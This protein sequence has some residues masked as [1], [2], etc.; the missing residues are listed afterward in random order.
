MLYRPYFS[1]FLAVLIMV[2]ARLQGAVVINE[3]MFHPPGAPENSA[4]EWIEIANSNTSPVDLSGWR[5]SK[6]VDFGFPNGTTIAAGGFLVVAANLNTFQTAHPGVTNVV[7]GWTGRLSNSGE[8][9]QLDR[10]DWQKANGVTYAD[11]GDWAVRARGEESFGH[12]GWVWVS[13]ADGGG[14]SLELRNAAL[15]GENSGQNWGPSGPVGGTPGAANSLASADVAPLITDVK[16]RPEIPHSDQAIVVS[17]DLANDDAGNVTATLH[18]RVDGAAAWQTLPM[19][20][21]DGDGDREAAIP[22]QANLAVIEFYVAASDGVNTRTWPAPA[23]TSNPGVAPETYAQVTNALLQVDNAFDPATNFTTPGQQPIYRLI[24]TNAERAELAQIGSTPAEKDSEATMNGTFISHDGQGVKTVYNAGFRNRG[25]ASALGPPNNYHVRFRNDDRWNGRGSF[26]LNCLFPHSQT[27]GNTLFERAGIAPQQAAIVQVRV[28]GANLAESGPRMYGR[29]ARVEGRGGEW[30]ERHFPDDA[31]GNFYRLDDHLYPQNDPRSGEFKF[32]GNDPAAYADTFF[33]ETN[34]DA[35]D[36]SDLIEFARVVSAPAT[37]GTA[38]QPAIS[39]AAYP[40][41]VAAKLDLEAFYRYMATDALIGNQE[42]GLQSGRADD[43]SIYRGVLDPRF[44]FVPH[45]LDDVFNIGA[46]VGNP[47]TRS[48][49]SYNA[50]TDGLGVEG[51]ARLFNHPQLLPRYYAAVLAAMDDWFNLATIGPIIDGIMAGWVPATDASAPPPNT[52]IAEIKAFVAQRRANVLAQIQQNYALNVTT[53]AANTAEGYSQTTDG[54]ATLG[55]TFNLAQ[56]YSITVNG[57]LAQSFYRTAGGD[58]AGTWKLVVPAGGGSI[59]RRGLNTVVVNFWGGP[60]GTGKVLQSL[61]AQIFY[62]A[63]GTNIS[64]T[65]N[66]N[67]SMRLL[68]PSSFIAG[69]P[70]LVRV[71]LL[72]TAGNLDRSAWNTTVALSAN[73]GGVVLPNVQLYNGMGSALI[74]AGGGGGG[75]PQVF[76]TY[77]TGGTGAAGVSG[78]PGSTWRTKTDLTAATISAVPGTWK[79]EGFDDSSWVQRQTQTGYGDAD[80][81]QT[82][83]RIDYDPATVGTQSAPS[84]LFRNTFTIAD[85]SQLATVA[86]EVKYDDGV[87]VYINGTQVL[88][89]TNLDPAGTLA[90][91]ADF[92]GAATRENATAALN[93]PLNLLHNGVNTIA[94]EVHQADNGS[95]DVTFD[96]R[97]QANFP[98]ADPGNFTLSA[99]GA[100]LSAQKAL[101]SLGSSPAMTNVSGTVATGA[102]TWSGVVHVTGDVTVPSGATLSIAPGT[103]VL[104]D[105]DASAGSTAG[106]KLIVQ[107][108]GAVDAAGT[109]ANP[110]SITST[111]PETRWGEITANGAT[112][113]KFC[114]I[115]HATHSIG[116]GH[117]GTGPVFR[118]G[119]T[120]TPFLIED[121]VVADNPGKTM[122]NSGSPDITMRRSHFARGVMGPELDGAGLTI[123]DCSFTEMLP[124]Y[125]ESGA[126]DDEDCIYIHDSGGKPVNVRRS[127]F[128]DCGDDGIDAL[129]GTIAFED[130][131]I[132]DAFDK[133]VSTNN[134]NALFR[135][136]QMIDNDI[137]VSTKCTIAEQNTPFVSTY[138]NCT[139]VSE[140]H[141]TNTSDGNFHS[142]GFHTRNKYGTTTMNVT[143]NV[144][145]CIIS[146]EEPVRND[147]AVAGSPFP[148]M[149]FSYTDFHDLGGALPNDPV[150]AGTGNITA[151]PL[152]VSFA[153]DNYRLQSG[154]PARDS[155][156][157]AS[158]LDP[159]GSRADMGALPFGEIAAPSSVTWTPGNGPYRI[160]A[161]TTVPV[162]TTLIVQPG[163]SVFFDQNV[164][165]TVNGRMLAQG[166]PGGRIVFSHVPGTIAP[167][168]ADPIKN[169]TQTGAP[170]WGGIRVFDSMAQESIF[171]HCDFINAQGTSPVG[172]ENFGSIG[173]I[174]SWGWVD[175]CTWAGTHLR[176]CYGRNAK[177]T[178]THNVFPDM[179]IFD[180]VLGR[181]EDPT[182][183]VS[184]ADNNQE[185][186][187]VEFP[188]TDPEVAA[189]PQFPNGQ[190]FGGHWRCY[191]NDFYGNRGHNDVMDADSGRWG[192]PGQFMFDCRYNHFH[193]LSGDEH[194]DLGGD[195]YIASN[196]FE[197]AT[198]DEWVSAFGTDL[199]Y[200][201]AISSGDKGEGTTIMVVRN[202]FFD[203]DHA[204]NC[205]ART[206]TIFE[207]NTVANFHADY[208]YT[209]SD[210]D[211]A[212]KN[213][214][215]N[216]FIP[217]DGP[218][219][220]YGDG[221]YLGFNIVSVTPHLFSGPDARKV[222]VDPGPGTD[223]QVVNDITTKIEFFHNLLDQIADPVI[224]PNH[225]GGFFSGTYGPNKAGAPGF[226]DAAAKNFAL[227][228]GSAA[229]G[230]AP[231]GLDYGFTVPEW[232]YIIGGPDAQTNATSASFKIGGPGIVAYQWRLDGGAWSA[233]I[234]IGAGGVLPRTG[235]TV[236][237]ATLNLTNLANG[238]HTLEVLGEDMAGN[239]Q[240]ADPARTL[241]GL[242]Q[243]APTARTWTVN[244]ALVLVRINEVLVDSATLPDSVELY[245]AGANPVPLDGWSISDGPITAGRFPIPA[246]TVLQAGGYLVI[247]ATGFTLDKDG[248]AVAL[249]NGA[250]LVDSVSFGPQPRDL[251]LG[252]M[253]ADG[254][255]TL[256]QPTPGAANVKQQLGSPAAVRINE[257]FADGDVRYDV[258][259]IELRNGDPLPV[260]LAGLVLTDNTVSNAGHTI[261][262]LSFV[263][264]GGYVRLIADGKPSSGPA[265]LGFQL[266][267]QQEEIAL[268]S[269]GTRTDLVIFGPQV[270][271]YSQG[272]DANGNFAFYELPTRPFLNGTSD[273]AYPNA[274][275]L[276]RGLRITEIMYHALGGSDYDF[277]ELR[278]V[279]AAPLDLAGVKFVQGI[280][281]T[282]GALTLAPGQDVLV[283][284]NLAQFRSRY[285]NTPIVAGTYGGQLDNTGERLAIQLPPPFDANILTFAF[286]SGWYPLATGEGRSLVIADPLAP[287]NVWGD[288]DSWRASAETGGNPGGA[289]A[290]IDTF[291]SWSAF[292]SVPSSDSDQDYDGVLAFAEYALAMDPTNPNSG[293]GRAGTP[294][295]L[296]GPNGRVRFLFDLPASGAAAQGHGVAEVVY[297]VQ[298]SE[299]LATWATIA[300]KSFSSAWSGAATVTVGPASN[301]FLPVS[302]EDVANSSGARY[303][304]LQMVFAP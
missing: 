17:T 223:Y 15:A 205:K 73:V 269:V 261:A 38:E 285:G 111:T 22:P 33:K 175:H 173:F 197:R 67:G 86:G 141:P 88:R 198:K 36:Y 150:P 80:E 182:D 40:A 260:S 262:P 68:A 232:A 212:V 101:T 185:P 154:S 56:T 174:R 302:V 103:H 54:A 140:N 158:P 293:E 196:I 258:D 234:R 70:F 188:T 71:D 296:P 203:L 90:S 99:S 41:A 180:P 117:T 91:Y 221:A 84:Y 118:L 27:L 97:L 21:T 273:P 85:V 78:T 79:N 3:I 263:A 183:F 144:K 128:A 29:Y 229:H 207:H 24:M 19:S 160:T 194:I 164:H 246:G 179:F 166:T 254:A 110:I 243:A 28:N 120:N 13:D 280:D 10:A 45:D 245:N 268:Y 199:G 157:P 30:A 143:V 230:T 49:F 161:N 168:D 181:I 282:F 206:A 35:N 39:D 204:I 288:R 222:D 9:V 51:L 271:D 281:F 61:T 137:G 249:Y 96:L 125:R 228:P 72:D 184:S 227:R 131:I 14:K 237:Q 295:V 58:A 152:Y 77:G 226:V 294:Q 139:V 244:T 219:P 284:K 100:G 265:H 48:L 106:K 119:G 238:P 52:S 34:Q 108:G 130:C 186:L 191:Y 264:G 256:T 279:G 12:R 298:A 172:S 202:L 23:R 250:T 291:S 83:T 102:T 289:S 75:A 127:V 105:G 217:E 25:F 65:L 18:W 57:A 242:P 233:R 87:V 272:R 170:K 278:N 297:H 274:L 44:R 214:P 59:L 32:E 283:V 46:G 155:G 82:F 134:N 66:G 109:L 218:A 171:S 303:L 81:N 20:D 146:A 165:L 69:K 129:G 190:P 275:A 216:F 112:S 162:G 266:E 248:D 200:S 124:A 251:P 64:G 98:S 132:R 115:S 26:G 201:N 151:D 192:Q 55:G 287:A 31:E 126:A 1:V 277:L 107:S 7:G 135:R 6:G 142:I 76:F 163:T 114:L 74:T 213:A 121:S 147:Y 156:D 2:S 252:R 153:T 189:N 16:H 211:Q 116:G 215:V 145:N 239:W 177:L 159:D 195:A 270:T 8:N 11:E 240:D 290:R 208:L 259:W 301:G 167:G 122:T 292:Y 241:E 95:S 50:G 276:L 5:I 53:N 210:P 149:N 123:E 37:G 255:W 300:T 235:P 236:R 133:G 247:T 304:R 63:P 62:G 92:N 224:G 93:I 148:L 286:N 253:G 220:S 176:M 89:T 257:W 138:E 4:L 267:A 94:V 104:I 113:W 60:N 193:G 136:C 299:D 187:K 178:V 42:G 225:P 209:A 231:G 169:G 43:T 47:I